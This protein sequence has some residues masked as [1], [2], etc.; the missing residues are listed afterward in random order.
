MKEQIINIMEL[1][2]VIDRWYDNE[3]F[4]NNIE[5]VMNDGNIYKGVVLPEKVLVLFNMKNARP[6]HFFITCDDGRRE[7][8]IQKIKELEFGNHR[9]IV[10]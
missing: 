10:Q 3:E 8:N 7:V 4:I 1:Y 2:N 9:Y 5:V 6:T